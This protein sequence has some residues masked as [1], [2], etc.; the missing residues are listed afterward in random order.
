M[1][2]MIPESIHREIMDT[3]GAYPHESGGALAVCGNMITGYY[4]DEQAGA[5][6]RFYRLS[7]D[8]ITEV[9]N[10][11]IEAGMQFGG[12]VHSHSPGNIVLSPMDIVTAE[13]TMAVN[14][15]SSLLM[16][17][18]CEGKLYCYRVVMDAE[19]RCSAV[20]TCLVGYCTAVPSSDAFSF[21]G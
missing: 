2:L 15:Y 4:F 14:G 12:F 1:Q 20:E 17:V 11:W 7:Q 9:G 16:A 3:I 8:R 19:K 13:R 10:Q 18:V 21:E 5:G 6:N